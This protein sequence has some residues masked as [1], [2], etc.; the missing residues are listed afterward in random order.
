VEIFCCAPRRRAR[1]GATESRPTGGSSLVYRGTPARDGQSRSPDLHRWSGHRPAP[2][3]CSQNVVHSTGS[4][5][6]SL[7]RLNLARASPMKRHGVSV[8]LMYFEKDRVSLVRCYNRRTPARVEASRRTGGPPSA[9]KIGV[10]RSVLAILQTRPS[11]R[12][13]R[14]SRDRRCARIS[15]RSKPLRPQ[16]EDGRRG[17]RLP[18]YRVA[19]GAGVSLA[20]I[21]FGPGCI[22]S[23]RPSRLS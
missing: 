9:R 20:R 6:A 8:D 4:Q 7:V 23:G 5:P 13:E 14:L 1:E 11:G 19:A 21:F 17:F 10:R 22:P 2:N 12:T 16:F 3:E 18:G 15:Q